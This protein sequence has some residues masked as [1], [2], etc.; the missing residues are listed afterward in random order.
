MPVA[1]WNGLPSTGQENHK[2]GKIFVGAT[3]P[4]TKPGAH[5]GP[6]RQGA[7]SLQEGN[8]RVV[9]DRVGSSTSNKADIICNFGHVLEKDVHIHSGLSALGELVLGGHHIEISLPAGH[10]CQPLVA[11]NLGGKRLSIPTGESGFGVKG[12]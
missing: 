2:S 5:A 7:P 6:P 12:F 11:N 4:V 9:V 8:S 3:Q 1:R 10:G